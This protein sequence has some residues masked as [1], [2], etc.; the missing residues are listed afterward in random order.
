MKIGIVNDVAMAAEALR[1]AVAGARKHDVRWIAR[2]GMEAVRLCSAK[3]PDLV[4]MDLIMPGLDGVEATRTIMRQAPCAILIVT[5]RPQD[6][7]G[8]VFRALGAG[9]LDV[10]ATPVLAGRAG[11][12]AG[13]AGA[14]GAAETH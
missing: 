9:A 12:A 1:R 14:A 2:S 10:A 7:A 11:G 5:A 4:L 13:M 8:Q 6:N 3:R